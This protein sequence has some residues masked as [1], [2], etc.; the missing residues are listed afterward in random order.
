MVLASKRYIALPEISDI[1]PYLWLG[2][3]N[4]NSTF[5]VTIAY[6]SLDLS[7]HKNS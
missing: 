5:T 3:E 4:Q 6:V 1:D 2:I 7:K